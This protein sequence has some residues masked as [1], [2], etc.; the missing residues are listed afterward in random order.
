[1]QNLK[2]V[3]IYKPTR[4]EKRK[5]DGTIIPGEFVGVMRTKVA[6][7]TPGAFHHVGTNKSTSWDFWGY[8]VSSVNGVLRWIDC[9]KSEYGPTIELFLE[10]PKSLRQIT[11]PFNVNN[12]HDVLNH[13]CGLGKEV[14][15]AMLNISYW[16]RV[17]TG[18]DGKPKLDKDNKPIWKKSISFR[19]VPPQFN[20]EQ[21]KAFA[22]E[23]GL[24]WQKIKKIGGD[25][26]NFEAEI[27]YWVGRVV[28]LQRFLLG[29]EKV[30]PFCWNSITASASDDT[31]LTLIEGEI[32]TAKNIYEAVKPL[33]KMPF[34]RNETTADDFESS[35]DP[36]NPTHAADPF[37][38]NTESDPG[39]PSHEVV[40]YENNAPDFGDDLPF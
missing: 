16:V 29:T 27:E 14:E 7:N 32:A 10:T 22:A 25:E 9:R 23:N 21:W 8:D 20:F 11:I 2:P 34:G 12:L 6:P 36:N 39:F 13:L 35:Y 31:A 33:Y 5:A 3:I 24:E 15:V 17:K 4:A 38:T 19:D 40:N 30:L 28:K 37:N 18:Q 26:W 1:M